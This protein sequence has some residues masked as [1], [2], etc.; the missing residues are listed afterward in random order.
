VRSHFF[1]F[2]DEAGRIRLAHELCANET[3]EVIVTTSGGLWRYRL[4]DLVR[5]TGFVGATPSLRFL[6]R[7]GNVSDLCGEKLSETFVAGAIQLVAAT[8]QQKPR[9]VLLAPEAV[10]HGWRYTLFLEG[11][12]DLSAWAKPMEA[13]L[14]LNPNYE[15]CRQLGQLDAL[16]ACA[17]GSG[18]HEIFLRHEVTH[19]KRLGDVKT[20]FLSHRTDWAQQFLRNRLSRT[21]HP[22]S[23]PSSRFSTATL[24]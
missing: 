22:P 14:R 11:D 19:G 16:Q 2:I 6:G 9:F 12:G 5:V 18:A 10:D 7:A 15:Y 23:Q 1:E 13:Q 17:I 3:Y 8:L 21:P 20:T 24:R 4:G